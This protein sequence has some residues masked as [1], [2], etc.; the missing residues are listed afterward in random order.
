MLLNKLNDTIEAP[1]FVIVQD[2]SIQ[3]ILQNPGELQVFNCVCCVVRFYAVEEREKWSSKTDFLLSCIGYAVGLG[4]IW[5]FPYLC[6]KSGGGAFLIPYFITLFLCGIPLLLMEMAIGQY[7]RFGPIGTLNKV[8]PIFKGV[9]VATV[10]VTFILT[11]YYNVIIAWTLYY[12]FSSFTAVL[13]WSNCQ[14]TWNSPNCYDD[15]WMHSNNSTN[16]SMVGNYSTV[17]NSSVLMNLIRPEKGGISP[18]QD[19]YDH[20]V[21]EKTDSIDNLGSIR[22]ELFAVLLLSWTLVYFSLW[23][24]IKVSGKIVYITVTLP[25]LLLF[26]FLINGVLLP[27]AV[28]GLIFLFK[29]KWHLLLDAKVWV[30]AAAQNFNSIGIGF[31]SIIAMASFN[32]RK[33][34]LLP[35]TL[36]IISVNTATSLI[37]SI[38]VF[39]TLGHIAEVQGRNVSDVV[40]QVTEL[41]S[42]D[43]KIS[44]LF[45]ELISSLSAK[46]HGQQCACACVSS[47]QRVCTVNTQP[48]YG[49]GLVLVAIPEVITQMPIP[50]LWAV[51]F[52][53]L[54]LL[55]GLDSQGG[56]YVF[57][58]V[59]HYASAISIMFIA[60]F[61]VIAITWFYGWYLNRAKRLATNIKE[62]TG[63]RPNKYFIICWY[64]ISPAL[65]FVRTRTYNREEKFGC[66]EELLAYLTA[67]IAIYSFI[68][69]KPLKYDNVVSYPDW[70][71]G[72]GWMVAMLSVI[73]V[74]LFAV[75]AIYKAP[76][77][78]VFQKL[79][80]ACRCELDLQLANTDY[81]IE[82]KGRKSYDVYKATK[83]QMIEL[84][85]TKNMRSILQEI[86]DIRTSHEYARMDHHFRILGAL[87]LS[88]F[89]L[90]KAITSNQNLYIYASRNWKLRKGVSHGL[91]CCLLLP[92]ALYS[93]VN[94]SSDSYQQCVILSVIFTISFFSSLIWKL[95]SR[96][97]FREGNWSPNL[98]YTM[99]NDVDVIETL[100]QVGGIGCL[101]IV[102]IL[103]LMH[104]KHFYEV[105]LAVSSLVIFPVVLY[106]HPMLFVVLFKF[107]VLSP[108]NILLVV[109]WLILFISAVLFAS[110][111]RI[112]TNKTI[113]RKFF[114]ALV[115]LVFTPGIIFA[116]DLI[117]LTSS[118]AFYL[119]VLLECV[120]FSKAPLFSEI[121]QSS[122][123]K[124]LDEKDQG[125]LVLSH[126]YLLLGCALPIWILPYFQESSKSVSFSIKHLF[127][128][129]EILPALSGVICLGIGDT[130]ASVVGSLYGR[131]HWPGSKKTVEGTIFAIISMLGFIFLLDHLSFVDLGQ[132]PKFWLAGCV[133]LTGILEAVTDQVDNL[134][135]PLFF[136]TMV[137]IK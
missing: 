127:H 82:E 102:F 36:T 26:A 45:E 87:T 1:E 68:D 90:E 77:Y 83:E 14:H 86:L 15:L 116:P 34:S 46:S 71:Q 99:Q 30:Y 81:T 39:S 31:G 53:I 24:G 65:I 92:S 20:R 23:K 97:S 47:A 126:I 85:V 8:A 27:G 40:A 118:A 130:F 114:H 60:F 111:C 122:F 7:M 2:Y 66:K 9:G 6:Y 137:S 33:S 56:I 121:I 105:F 67:A 28:D 70:A 41:H 98:N 63:K 109:S 100:V 73:C 3:V 74:P 37:G 120:R 103:H 115:V 117:F 94:S 4:N 51:L 128:H 29:P 50:Q 16:M 5:R 129:P 25:Y 48:H 18:S 19:F 95:L 10:V 62:M 133:I 135:L 119:F 32:E 76:G 61:E 136:Y 125:F 88:L 55:L 38:V 44:P 13:P 35:E 112:F 64:F 12:L 110:Y 101:L 91:W 93:Q 108:V 104:D 124:L 57:Q 11:T 78:T 131:H 106:K 123:K 113:I 69:Y 52:F 54:L 134:I 132:I 22:W 107:V 59:D 84:G 58:L 96:R 80:N 49:P 72:L 43:E 75:I 79:R 17:I 42:R 89:C 21:L